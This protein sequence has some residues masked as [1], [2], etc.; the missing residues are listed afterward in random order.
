MICSLDAWLNIELFLPNLLFVSVSKYTKTNQNSHLFLSKK[1]KNI[2]WTIQDSLKQ[3]LWNHLIGVF[4]L[5]GLEFCFESGILQELN[6]VGKAAE[7]SYLD[8]PVILFRT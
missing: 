6:S 8:I 3:D 4:Q 7:L 2:K 5:L 1:P